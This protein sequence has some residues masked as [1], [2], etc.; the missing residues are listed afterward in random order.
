MPVHTRVP[1][2]VARQVS[3]ALLEEVSSLGNCAK[4]L[5]R[6]GGFRGMVDETSTAQKFLTNFLRNPFE[7][8]RASFWRL[9]LLDKDPRSSENEG[10][11]RL[12]SRREKREKEG[13]GLN[14]SPP[15]FQWIKRGNSVSSH[16]TFADSW[17][18]SRWQVKLVDTELTPD[19]CYEWLFRARL[20]PNIFFRFGLS[21]DFYN[22]LD[23]CGR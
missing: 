2:R 10:N 15:P 22:T 23:N 13:R 18:V 8:V 9:I 20:W 19:L 6:E 4:C 16:A 1:W 14:R 5:R 3:R 17:L 12:N 11:P 7:I 21:R